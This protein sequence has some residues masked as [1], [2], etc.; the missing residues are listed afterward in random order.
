MRVC[1]V[2]GSNL[3]FRKQHYCCA[4]C[5]TKGAAEYQ[6]NWLRGIDS[7]I[8]ETCGIR[9][10]KGRGKF[11]SDDCCQKYWRAEIKLRKPPKQAIVF[12][13]KICVICGISYTPKSENQKFCSQKC[14]SKNRKPRPKSTPKRTAALCPSCGVEFMCKTNQKYCS[15]KC[16]RRAHESRRRRRRK[17]S[18]KTRYE[19]D[20]EYRK[21][22]IQKAIEYQKEHP[23]YKVKGNIR[24]RI[25]T[26]LFAVNSSSELIGC[27][28]DKLRIWL[29]SKWTQQMRWSNY[30]SYWV[31]DH[32]IPLSS[33]DLSDQKQLRVACHYTNLQPMLKWRNAR[34]SD[35][36]TDPQLSLLL[37]Q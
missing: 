16:S 29:E 18:K 11:C 14:K 21:R 15:R 4:E 1:R 30:G 35:T 12:P 2:C 9:L 31:V 19:L 34:K 33:F 13:D 36:I 20:E 10:P 22:V 23:I 8:C 24:K 37:P 32:K 7:R 5:K 17:T 25:R 6:R 3:P 27:S 26:L 28:S